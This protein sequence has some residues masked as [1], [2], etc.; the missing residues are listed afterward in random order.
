MKP[1][2]TVLPAVALPVS[3]AIGLGLSVALSG[4]NSAPADA[5]VY[6][7]RCASCHSRS[8]TGLARLYPP[9]RSSPYLNDR[10][11]EL[12]CLVKNGIRGTITTR[13]GSPSLRMP[14]F[15]NLSLAEMSTL[16]IYLRD[17]WGS[18]SEPISEEVV[19]QWLQRCR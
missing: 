5:S 18:G 15:T 9:L 3:A 14:A 1:R 11:E 8:G 19:G 6:L 4:C 7:K 13:D 12:P 16:I 17:T 10:I 2:K